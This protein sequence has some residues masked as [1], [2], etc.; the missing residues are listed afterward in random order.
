[1][2][3]VKMRQFQA[4]LLLIT[5]PVR[6]CIPSILSAVIPHVER[7]LYIYFPNL[8]EPQKKQIHPIINT[9]YKQL[10]PT[11]NP[12]VDILLHNVGSKVKSNDSIRLPQLCQ[13]VFADYSNWSSRLDLREYC[14]NNFQSLARNFELRVI[15]KKD[16]KEQQFDDNEFV[17]S[18]KNLF[19]SQSTS[20]YNRGVLGG[21]YHCIV[22]FLD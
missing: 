2:A 12:S 14:L 7:N 9:I 5:N 18:D 13:V 20:Q 17:V 1:M 19:N 22:R 4:A 16:I 10:L 8:V 11:K 21:K 15:D 6:S 3:D